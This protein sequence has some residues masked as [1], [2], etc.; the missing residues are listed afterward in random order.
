MIG[1]EISTKNY[2]RAIEQVGEAQSSSKMKDKAISFLENG[3]EKNSRA[4]RSRAGLNQT[5]IGLG[6]PRNIALSRI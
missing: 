6:K 3:S 2:F 5:K 4:V 1:Q